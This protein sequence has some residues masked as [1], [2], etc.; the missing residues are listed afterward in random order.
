MTYLQQHAKF[1][2][3]QNLPQQEH[4]QNLLLRKEQPLDFL[5]LTQWYVL[6]TQQEPLHQDHLFHLHL[7]QVIYHSLH[8]VLQVPQQDI[9]LVHQVPLQQL[10]WV[11]IV[12]PVHIKMNPVQGNAKCVVHENLS[13]HQMQ[14]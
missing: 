9:H 5:Y 6:L 10:Q 11:G 4:L 8:L 14:L 2:V 3:Q 1:V 13:I 12:M 7:V